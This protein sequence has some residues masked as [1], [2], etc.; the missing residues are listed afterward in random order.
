V[1]FTPSLVVVGDELY[2][3]SDNGV[4]TCLDARTGRQRWTERLG[5][6][7]SASP[8]YADGHVYFLN[9]DGVTSVVK[10]GPTYQL[11][12]ANDLGE[13]ALASP[14]PDDGTLYVRTQSHL[15]R[16]RN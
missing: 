16:I 9:E 8:T 10:A 4:A 3:V 1:P 13:R 15:W 6:S 12:A 11:V 14:T 2:F 5:G 7:F